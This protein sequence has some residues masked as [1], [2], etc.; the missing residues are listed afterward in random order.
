MKVSKSQTERVNEILN[1]WFGSDPHKPLSEQEKWWKVDPHFDA[2]VR[3]KFEDDFKRAVDGRYEDWSKTARG[4]L[5]LILLFD[6]FSRN[7]Y[8]GTPE[9]F[10]QDPIALE[11]ALDGLE[12]GQDR[13]LSLVERW[14]FYMPLEHSEELDI[15]KKS[16]K[17][18]ETLKEE[19]D[20]NLTTALEHA[21]E[22]A[23]RHYEIVQRFGRFPH[24]NTIL[25]RKST[26]SE[27]EF[28]KE[29]NSSF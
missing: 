11:V 18:F 7:I 19:A 6:Q 28:L 25:G 22:F 29:P 12:K 13:E 8:R 21:H 17:L 2:E 23:L 27:E 20:G 16:V 4:S 10:A 3:K 1:F 9:A 26:R 24:R 15:Q 5:A 14:F